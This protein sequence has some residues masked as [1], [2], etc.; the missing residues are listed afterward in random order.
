[1]CSPIRV[2]TRES[3]VSPDRDIARLS[4]RRRCVGYWFHPPRRCPKFPVIETLDAHPDREV[5]SA[6]VQLLGRAISANP[7]HYVGRLFATAASPRFASLTRTR[8]QALRASPDMHAL[9]PNRF[10]AG[11]VLISRSSQ[12]SPRACRREGG[13]LRRHLRASTDEWRDIDGSH[14]TLADFV[15][16]LVDLGRTTCLR[17]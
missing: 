7:R 11:G 12:G 1:M 10:S 17:H 16:A 13:H 15:K 4:R 2:A 8:C 5:C 9:L 6:L 3:R 14:L